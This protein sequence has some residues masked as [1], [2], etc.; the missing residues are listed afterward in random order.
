[1]RSYYMDTKG[2]NPHPKKHNPSSLSHGFQYVAVFGRLKN[3][4]S[5][6]TEEQSSTFYQKLLLVTDEKTKTGWMIKVNNTNIYGCFFFIKVHLVPELTT[7]KQHTLSYCR[8]FLPLDVW[9]SPSQI[10][11]EPWIRCN[12]SLGKGHRMTLKQ[13]VC[14]YQLWVDEAQ[15]SH[16][17]DAGGMQV[18]VRTHTIPS[19]SSYFSVEFSCCGQLKKAKVQVK[20]MHYLGSLFSLPHLSGLCFVWIYSMCVF[21]LSVRVRGFLFFPHRDK[22]CVRICSHACFQRERVLAGSLSFVLLLSSL[23]MCAA[24]AGFVQIVHAKPS[25]CGAMI[26]VQGQECQQQR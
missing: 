25:E 4:L 6:T 21:I 14:K 13:C 20:H 1:M 19:S 11:S 16:S 10:I 15:I 22:G 2:I 12:L 24:L 26:M 9:H 17:V 5:E 3:F 18:Q 8:Q 7:K 23:C